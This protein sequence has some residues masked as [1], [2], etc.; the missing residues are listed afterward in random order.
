CAAFRLDNAG[1]GS[2]WPELVLAYNAAARPH[3]VVLPQGRWQCLADGENSF[4]WRAEKPAGISGQAVLPAGAALVLG[5]L[6]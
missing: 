4:L 3:A 1:P 2:R 6:E 5:R